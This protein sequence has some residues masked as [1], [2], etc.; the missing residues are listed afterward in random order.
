[1]EIEIN[2]PDGVDEK[3]IRIVTENAAAL[4][5]DHAGFEKE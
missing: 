4:K 3:I 2:V 5:F 1:M